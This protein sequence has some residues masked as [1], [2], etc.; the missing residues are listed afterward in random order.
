MNMTNRH[1]RFAVVV[2]E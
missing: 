1:A 2:F